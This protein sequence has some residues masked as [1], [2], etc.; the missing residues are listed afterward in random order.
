MTLETSPSVLY[1]ALAVPGGRDAVESLGN[2]G[3]AVEFVKDSYRH[4][5]P[6]LAIG[7]GGALLDSAGASESL[8]SGEK[9][10]GIL[11]F[12]AGRAGEAR[13]DL[14]DAH[15]PAGGTTRLS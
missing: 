13:A 12:E 6:I 2:I 14:P 11:A 7:A 10:P 15:G 4:C 9:D 1:D 8:M 5:K 3:H